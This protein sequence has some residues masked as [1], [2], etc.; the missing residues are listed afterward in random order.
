MTLKIGDKIPAFTA[1]DTFA[2]QWAELNTNTV[3]QVTLNQSI[4]TMKR[5]Q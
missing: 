4:F 1:N 2:I 3:A 5:L